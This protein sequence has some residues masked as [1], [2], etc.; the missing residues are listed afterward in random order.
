MRCIDLQGD[1]VVVA[2]A[3]G[4]FYAFSD[5]CTHLGCS[6]SEGRLEGTVVT[7]ARDGSQ[8]D[9]RSGNVLTGPAANRIRTYRVQAYGDEIRI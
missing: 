2:N 1:R 6:L 4:L 3:G 7:C 9:I 5:V 8:F